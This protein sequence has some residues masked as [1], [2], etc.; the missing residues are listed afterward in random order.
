[1]V[2]FTMAQDPVTIKLT[3]KNGLPD[4][5]FY[6]IIEDQNRF[7]W[8]AADKGLF[9]YDGNEYVSYSN[10]EKRGL[11]VFGLKF[12]N[13]NNLWCNN[14]S[15]QFFKIV[16]NQLVLVFDLKKEL[17]GQL[18]EY[19]F[20]DDRIIIVSINS[21]ISINLRTNERTDLYN[22]LPKKNLIVRSIYKFKNQLYFSINDK[23]YTLSNSKIIRVTTSSIPDYTDQTLLS[24]FEFNATL[25]LKSF[26][27]NS[28]TNTFY[29]ISKELFPIELPE[30]LTNTKI[31]RAKQ[32]KDK[33]WFCTSNGIIILNQDKNN[34]FKLNNVYYNNDFITNFI[35]DH[36]NTIF[37]TTLNNGVFIIPE[38]NIKIFEDKIAKGVNSAIEKIDEKTIAFGTIKGE[39][40]LRNQET[41]E[42][43]SIQLNSSA[44]VTALLYIMSIKSLLI[45][46]ENNSF[47]YNLQNNKLTLLE[48][49]I[50]NAKDLKKIENTNKFIFCGYNSAS[51]MELKKND[52]VL[53]KELN[54]KRAYKCFYDEETKAI[55]ISFVDNVLKFD[56]NFTIKNILYKNKNIVG[57]DICKT[58]DGTM[59]I[60]TYNDGILGFKND[61]FFQ[62]IDQNKGL[63]SNVILQAQ[64]D[65]NNLLLVTDL[66]VQVY[67]TEDNSLQV[68]LNNKNTSIGGVKNVIVKDSCLLFATQYSFFEMSKKSD[69]KRYS[70]KELYIKSIAINEK[71]TILSNHYNLPHHKNRI[72]INFHVNGYFPAEELQFEYRLI[73]LNNKWIP[74]EKNTRFINFNGLSSGSY[75]F[76]IR[77]KTISDNNY[78]S[79]KIT[80]KINLPFWK[81]WWFIS[82]VALSIFGIL[83]IFYRNKLTIKEKEKELALKNAK[84]ENELAILKLENLKSQMNP[85][86]IFNALNSIQEY[87]I[88]NQ[89]NLASSYLAKFAELIRAYLEH[90]SKGYITIREEIECLDIYLQ[91][92]KLRFEDKFEYSL[93]G[94]DNNNNL[95]IPT[96][97]IQPYV[98]NAI[99]HGLLHKKDNRKLTISFELIKNQSMLKCIVLDN[100]IGR[101]KANEMQYKKHNSFASEATA[102]RLELL[103]FGKEKKIGV[104]IKDLYENAV[105]TGTKITLLIPILN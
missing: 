66:G 94:I 74:I 57:K 42:T 79:K 26:N 82:L 40:F 97:L 89:K 5:E 13:Q 98:E 8:L 67:N 38:L 103:N 24:F 90:S 96:M 55:Y 47:I 92:E 20:I 83:I 56:K 93:N 61:V 23:V 51:V 48:T 88:L 37:I 9:R 39:L 80:F 99:K 84:F 22:Q 21:I 4:V 30:I 43:T 44:K 60:T 17:K 32:M 70:P 72:Q 86:F 53:V 49:S 7:I 76:E 35:E 91:L 71:D 62:K 18:A 64:S 68:K 54:K 41:S 85:H 11:S 81:T 6:D 100:G 78:V 10:K 3:E 65:G 75:V 2:K 102:H 16:N 36:N 1:M 101:V 45:S 12:D 15:G 63:L 14:I 46:T 19:L 58:S 52:V 33:I 50:R 104:E 25:Y 59:W 87:I 31:I 105:A 29:Q 34:R 95:K 28:N 69:K 77:C 27:P 73:G